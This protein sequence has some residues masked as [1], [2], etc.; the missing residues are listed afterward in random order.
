MED[1]FI[2]SRDML[3]YVIILVGGLYPVAKG[4]IGEM[5]KLSFWKQGFVGTCTVLVFR[6]RFTREDCQSSTRARVFVILCFVGV[7][8]FNVTDAL[9]PL[10]TLHHCRPGE[11]SAACSV[12]RDRCSGNIGTVLFPL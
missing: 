3:A 2:T 1:S 6:Q 11:R 9:A 10:M 12:L 8:P 7:N 4:N 5:M